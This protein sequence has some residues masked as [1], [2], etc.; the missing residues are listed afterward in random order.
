MRYLCL[1][2][3][4]EK[5]GAAMSGDDRTNMWHEYMQRDLYLYGELTLFA[6]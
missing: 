6:S 2:Y 5:Q 3:N 1:I 4:N